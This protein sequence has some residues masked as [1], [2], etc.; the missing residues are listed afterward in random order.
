MEKTKVFWV[1]MQIS[2]LLLYG[3]LI[4]GGYILKLPGLGWGLFGTLIILHVFELN[5]A[6][7]IGKEKG[8]SNQR[9]IAKNMLFGFTWWVPLKRGIITK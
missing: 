3:V 6:F 7:R 4:E 2:A 9:I 8:L 1:W 5:S